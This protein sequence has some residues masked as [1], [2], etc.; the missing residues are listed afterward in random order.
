MSFA[1][2]D[3]VDVVYTGTDQCE[4]ERRGIDTN[5]TGTV[6]GGPNMGMYQVE[7]D[8]GWAPLPDDPYWYVWE[9]EMHL[10]VEQ[11]AEANAA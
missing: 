8:E 9:N 1:I 11:P 3:R 7:A 2:G 5:F 10:H 4:L 6:V